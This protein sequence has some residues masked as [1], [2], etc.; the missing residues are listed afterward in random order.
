MKK[1]LKG[2]LRAMNEQPPFQA[3]DL[4]EEKASREEVREQSAPSQ[5]KNHADN[6]KRNAE[7]WD[8]VHINL[9]HAHMAAGKALM[10]PCTHLQAAQCEAFEKAINFCE[11]I[12]DEKALKKA[13]EKYRTENFFEIFK[14]LPAIGL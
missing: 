5:V 8:M 11:L 7:F 6:A 1:F 14:Q 10:R 12:I 2:M 13:Q 4:D 3:I 9:G